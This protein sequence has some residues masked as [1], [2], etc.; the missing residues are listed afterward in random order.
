M[1]TSWADRWEKHPELRTKRGAQA[2]SFVVFRLNEPSTL[3]FVKEVS[4]K[5]QKARQ[6][7][8]REV[9]IYATLVDAGLPVMYEH[10]VG[11]VGD[12]KVP[13]YLVIEYIP[14]GTLQDFIEANG[15]VSFEAAV[16]FVERVAPVLSALHQEE[17]HIG[18]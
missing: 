6:R 14:G 13:L 7:F 8:A 9:T 15:P 10:N 5:S 4:A 16:E 12:H 3:G 1:P 2:N 17:W 11:D 18:T